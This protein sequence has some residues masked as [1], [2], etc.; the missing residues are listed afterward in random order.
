MKRY[1][2]LITVFIVAAVY[3]TPAQYQGCGP[4]PNIP[5]AQQQNMQQSQAA[6]QAR[7]ISIVQA[8]FDYQQRVAQIQHSMRLSQMQNQGANNPQI[9]QGYQQQLR[10]LQEQ[11]QSQLQALQRQ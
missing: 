5:T 8:Q 2:L 10:T 9:M 4:T 11:F 3:S 6:Q 1:G 7:Q